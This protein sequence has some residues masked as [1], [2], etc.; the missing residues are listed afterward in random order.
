MTESD[1]KINLSETDT[2]VKQPAVRDRFILVAALVA[3]LA[4]LLFTWFGTGFAIDK[5]LEDE[6]TSKALRWGQ[7][8]EAELG[9][10]DLLLA[11][12]HPTDADAEIIERVIKVGGIFRFKFINAHAVVVYASRESDMG[13]TIL[14]S[15]FYD[16]VKKGIPYTKI[17]KDEDF[18]DDKKLVTEAYIPVLKDDIF[19]GAIEVY[20]DVTTRANELGRYRI[21]AFIVSFG[22][23]LLLGGIL[24]IIYVRSKISHEVAEQSVIAEQATKAVNEALEKRVAQRTEELEHEIRSHLKTEAELIEA[25]TKAERANSAKAVFL[26]SISHELR[27]PMNAI[28]GF[29]QVLKR[30]AEKKLTARETENVQHIINNGNQLVHLVDQLLSLSKLQ[31]GERVTKPTEFMINDLIEEC[32]ED[33]DAE[34]RV[35]GVTLSSNIAICTAKTTTVD[36]ECLKQALLNLLSNAIKYNKKGGIVDVSCDCKADGRIRISVLDTGNGIPKNQRDKVFQSFD[37]LGREGHA[38]EGVGIGLSITKSLVDLIKG[39]IGFES[40]VG[41]GSTFWIELPAPKPH[42][43]S[44]K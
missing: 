14:H 35:E 44:A 24:A 11:K 4:S 40:V 9:D 41:S 31:S 1:T 39:E 12:G 26:S 18:G 25:I 38:I 30:S 6:S 34:A 36:R 3:G 21:V 43:L 27:T 5:I 19:R 42:A 20:R 17:E 16:Y 7:L 33:T 15:Y 28:M 32:I 10:L 22:F 2:P 37:K 29:A 23:T 8:L 13:T